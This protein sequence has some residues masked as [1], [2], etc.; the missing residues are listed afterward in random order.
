MWH[1]D[2]VVRN[3][4]MQFL[5]WLIHFKFDRKTIKFLNC[6]QTQNPV[7][8][9]PSNHNKNHLQNWKIGTVYSRIENKNMN[10]LIVVFT[11][12]RKRNR[13]ANWLWKNPSRR[14]QRVQP[15]NWM[16]AREFHKNS[17]QQYQQTTTK[18]QSF[19]QKGMATFKHVFLHN[20]CYSSTNLA[21][22]HRFYS[23]ILSDSYTNSVTP[24]R[25]KRSV[26][27]CVSSTHTHSQFENLIENIKNRIWW[28]SWIRKK[29]IC[30]DFIGTNDD[31]W[32]F[33]RN[34]MSDTF[35]VVLFH[36]DFGTTEKNG[37]IQNYSFWIRYFQRKKSIFV[38]VQTQIRWNR[39]KVIKIT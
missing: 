22:A 9:W 23:P 11:I 5:I 36:F 8:F 18:L 12:D 34:L 1:C 35:F 21:A 29:T 20:L 13:G 24:R 26:F 15:R 37:Q 19:T 6:F 2:N 4:W 30:A 27:T 32:T 25:M 16:N 17:K 31:L 3:Y 14:L 33:E 7:H 28:S 10:R 38:S 39:E